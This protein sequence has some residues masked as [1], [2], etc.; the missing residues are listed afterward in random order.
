MK[1]RTNMISIY[2]KVKSNDNYKFT[3]FGNL[4]VILKDLQK[5]LL[6]GS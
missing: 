5:S 6:L 2:D 4:T 3:L 1:M